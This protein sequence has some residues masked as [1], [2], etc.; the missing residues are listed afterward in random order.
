M[1]RFIYVVYSGRARV[2]AKNA[3]GEEVTVGA[4]TRGDSFGEQGL[5]SHEP[6]AFTVR[7]TSDLALLRLD[8]TDFESLLK[9]RPTLREYFDKY[10]SEISIRNFLKLCTVFSPLSAEE[11]RNL[12]GSM[13]I[14]DYPAHTAIIR[15]GELGDAFYILRSGSADVIK[16]S[17]GGRLLNH[18]EAGD[19]FGELALLTGQARAA[20]VITTEAS[21]V[22]VWK[23]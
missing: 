4:L 1:R 22:F 9:G 6:R 11:I 8:K 18:L 15:E 7:A 5:L 14:R 23:E 12:L 20:S 16:E 13:V 10:I 21:S 3:T 2:I 19:S 17:D